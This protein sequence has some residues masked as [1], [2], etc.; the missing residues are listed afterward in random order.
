MHASIIGLLSP[1]WL[2]D[3][4]L[5]V[6]NPANDALLAHVATTAAAE[7]PTIIDKSAEAQ[8]E[9]AQRTVFARGRILQNFAALMRDHAE[10]LGQL[11]TIE[12]GKPLSESVG[13]IKYAA[14]F[15]D[16]AAEDAKRVFGEMVP[17][18]RSGH[19]IMVLH[20]PVG[21]TAAITPWNFPSAMI[22]R[23]LG[24]ALAVGCSMI[25]KPAEQTPLS[26]LALRDLAT[27]A[28]IPADLFTVVVGD[29]APL[30]QAL[31]NDSRVRAVSFTGSTE[32]GKILMRQAANNVTRLGL[33]LGG[34]APFIVFD[35]ADLDR[36]VDGAMASKF[37]NAG[38]TCI[39]AN[40]ILIQDAIYDRFMER[41]VA[42]TQQ[43]VV[44]PG[45]KSGVHIGP[46]IDDAGIHKVQT[47]LDD[48]VSRGATVTVGGGQVK[49]G[50]GL[51]P[52]FYAP[53]ILEGVTSDMLVSREE[54]FGPIAP[55]RRFNTEQEAIDIA[56]DSD[57]GLAAYFYSRDVGRVMRVGEALEYGIV[58]AND[59]VPSTA[60]APFGGFKQ[61]GLG[62]EGGHWALDE[63]LETKFLSLAL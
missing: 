32:V 4:G 30:G 25:V 19:R 18:R 40:R 27:E 7:M 14:T 48:A 23:K 10:D 11:L 33:E 42:R 2:D 17:S 12:Q 37:R 36:A 9:W 35:D 62:R 43:L 55:V 1:R 45:W 47:H 60:E 20:Q 61:S 21:V 3:S 53:T 46:L 8:R 52:R 50:P 57:F 44:G 28:G 58:G 5:A 51:A 49:G 31:F 39:C 41:F 59:G 34:H 63:Y 56:N 29:P 24:P 16:Q 38:Q 26:A 54:T 6:H 13:E 22:T 15:L